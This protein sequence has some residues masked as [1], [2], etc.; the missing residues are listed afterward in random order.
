[1]ETFWLVVLLVVVGYMV[2]ATVGAFR[3]EER[4]P[5]LILAIIGWFIFM[6]LASQCMRPFA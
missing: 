5:L 2:Y 1:M 3:K 6:A 4:K